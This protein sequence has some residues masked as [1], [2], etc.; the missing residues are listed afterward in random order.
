MQWLTR[1]KY[2]I[3]SKKDDEQFN[4]DIECEKT[5]KQIATKLD[6]SNYENILDVQE[7]DGVVK[8]LCKGDRVFVVNRQSSAKQI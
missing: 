5:L 7:S 3:S 2:W 6:E 8:V 1:P 4:Y